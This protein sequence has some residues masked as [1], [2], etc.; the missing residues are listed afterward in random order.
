MMA[1][2]EVKCLI[3]ISTEFL[4]RTKSSHYSGT[5]NYQMT[6]TDYDTIKYDLECLSRDYKHKKSA[7]PFADTKEFVLL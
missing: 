7:G 3:E 5:K 2:T 6:S 1:G 4:Y